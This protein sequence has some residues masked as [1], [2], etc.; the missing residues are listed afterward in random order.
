MKRLIFLTFILFS[1]I[2]F[3][4]DSYAVWIWTPRTG[5]WVNPKWAVKD[6]PEDQYQWAMSFFNSKDYDKSVKEFEKL[7]RHFPRSKQAADA[8]YYVG[9]SFEKMGYYYKAFQAYQKTIEQYP[10]TQKYDEIIARELKMG[11]YFYSGAKHKYMGVPLYPSYGKAA[12]I[13]QKVNENAPF[14]KYADVSLF[15]AGESFKKAGL[16]EEAS[17]C[18]LKLTNAYPDSKLADS[19]KFQAAY[20]TLKAS[21]KPGYDSGATDQAIA[22][23]DKF[24]SNNPESEFSKD[25]NE[26]LDM[27][28]EKKAQEAFTV[29]KFYES[30]DKQESAEIYYKEIVDSYPRSKYAKQASQKLKQFYSERGQDLVEDYQPQLISK[31]K[32]PSLIV[33]PQANKEIA[34]KAPVFIEDIMVENKA[35]SAEVKIILSGN[36]EASAFSLDNPAKVVLDPIGPAFTRLSKVNINSR[37]IITDIRIL[38]AE[39][40]ELAGVGSK[41]YPVDLI[42]ISLRRFARCNTVQ[43]DGSITVFIEGSQEQSVQ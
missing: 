20:C 2:S 24:V 11:E 28:Y 26:A 35:E 42:T 40:E 15:K 30:Q 27:L 38:A 10:Y 36:M 3:A 13:F 4:T 29:A 43:N 16:F 6:T 25:A 12:E 8:Q 31:K 22:E 23:F 21:G 41:D 34:K 17:L 18:F 33:L 39:G 9:V 1:V 32:E 14:G 37:G 19:A 5:K 7:V